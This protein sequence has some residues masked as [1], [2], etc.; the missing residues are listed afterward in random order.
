M[1]WTGVG[2]YGIAPPFQYG[3][4]QRQT[5]HPVGE[6]GL[7]RS[8]FDGEE[9]MRQRQRAR[10]ALALMLG[11][12]TT[13][14]AADEDTQP[15]P[16][17]SY[18]PGTWY[19]SSDPKPP[20]PKVKKEPAAAPKPS[21]VEQL[22]QQTEQEWNACLRRQQVCDRL[23]ELALKTD[24]AEL[25]RRVEELKE[26]VFAV[27]KKRMASLSGLGADGPPADGMKAPGKEATSRVAVQGGAK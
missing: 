20:P 12:A 8:D 19:D 13:G 4:T 22:A 11:L 16:H 10:I 26:R 5:T 25:S 1:P 15:P 14:F 18:R 3:I 7:G 17:A 27:Y 9:S 6:N 24:N 21:P 2:D 23:A